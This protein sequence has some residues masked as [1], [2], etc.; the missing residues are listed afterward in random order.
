MF[1]VFLGFYTHF[2][3]IFYS[4]TEVYALHKYLRFMMVLGLFWPLLA[5]PSRDVIF[6]VVRCHLTLRR[7]EFLPR[8]ACKK[9]ILAL[10]AGSRFH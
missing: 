4:S 2:G 10:R 9:L 7:A 8:S 1:S 6:A 5:Q 3:D